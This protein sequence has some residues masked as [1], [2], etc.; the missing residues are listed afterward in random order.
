M[1]QFHS[2]GPVDCEE[3]FC[4]ERKELIQRC[5]NQLVGNPEK[6]GHYFTIWAP[7]QTGKTWLMQQVT[8]EIE[9]NYKDRF[10][11]YSFSLGRLRGMNYKPSKASEELNL[12]LGL[13]DV[14]E[15]ELPDHPC[16]KTWKEFYQFF[17]RDNG[18]WKRPLIL[19]I[20]EVDTTPPLLLDIIVNLFR[21]MY[22]KREKNQVHGLALIGVRAVLG[23]E[24]ER[25][26]PFN[27]QRSLHMPNFTWEEVEDLCQQYQDESGQA[28]EQDVVKSVF[29]IT[30]GQPGL[31]CW[32]GEMLTE[33]YNPGAGKSVD[34]TVWKT[35]YRKACYTEWNNTVLNLI[36]KAKAEYLP[37]VL[38]LFTRPDIRFSLDAEWCSYLYLN[39]VIDANTQ[40]DAGGDPVE[41]CCFSSPFVQERLF[42]ALT[43]DLIGD[44]MPILVLEPL[45]DLADVFN[46]PELDLPA[47]LERYKSYL[48]RLKIK[49]LNPWKDQPRRVDMH[50]TEAVGHFHLYS[51]L[52]ETVES[53]CIVSP[54]FPTGN[55]KVDLHLKCGEKRGIVEVKSFRS[56]TKTES[57][58]FQAAKYAESLGMKTV[59]IALFTP[60]EDE[61]VLEELSGQ[62]D[63]DG[64]KVTVVAI[65]WV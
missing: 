61:S 53:Q 34:M 20:D 46:K 28:V 43:Q 39:G 26:S 35:V 23:V 51:W 41:F 25:G 15:G 4:V 59:T 65:G 62:E 45:D 27:I 3:H 18:I 48:K 11:V 56:L 49:G 36:K 60:V 31:V 42:N 54:E 44:R 38:D 30:R 33:K 37:H 22:L 16:I 9:T 21:E 13:T 40:T 29:E 58:K 24:S 50:L 55:G 2:Y 32:F 64:V 6:G 47:L 14:L 52:K 10:A 12:P 5:T 57:A 17:S 7:R 19:F 1:R 8:Q 63:I